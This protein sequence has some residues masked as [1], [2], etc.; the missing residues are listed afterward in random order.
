MGFLEIHLPLKRPGIGLA[1]PEG[2][3]I[4]E[5]AGYYYISRGTE[6]LARLRKRSAYPS[7]YCRRLDDK[8]VVFGYGPITVSDND[9]S[10]QVILHGDGSL[11]I[12]RDYYATLPIFYSVAAGIFVLSNSYESVVCA[13]P[14]ATLN[15]DSLL[16]TLLPNPD[17]H[18]DLW[19]EVKI[20]EERHILT[21]DR[22]QRPVVQLP[23]P[24]PWASSN[25][26]GES[27]PRLFKDTLE[28][29]LEAFIEKFDMDGTLAFEVSGGI[30]SALLPLHVAKTRKG[31]VPGILGSMGFPGGFGATQHEKLLTLAEQ[32]DFRALRAVIDPKDEYPLARIVKGV[33][34]PPFYCFSEIYSEPLGDLADRFAQ[35]GVQVVATGIGGDELFENTLSAEQ[36]LFF[37]NV[38]QQRRRSLHYPPFSTPKMREQYVRS[39]PMVAPYPLPLLGVSLHGA[40]LARNNIYI[41]RDIWPVSPFANAELYQFCQ[42]LPVRFRANKNILRAFYEAHSFPKTI[43]QPSQNEHFGEFFADSFST[44]RYG[45]L[46]QKLSQDSI[47]KRLGLIDTARLLEVYKEYRAGTVVEGR[48]WLLYIYT[49]L[50]AELNLQEEQMVELKNQGEILARIQATVKKQ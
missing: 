14:A 17:R 23:D 33:Q 18:A 31:R 47:T 9:E 25:Q 10:L 1:E 41:S 5:Q 21:I 45:D 6:Q 30:D 46:I 35:Q 48:K 39:A 29:S 40:Q 36:Q 7:T 11:A 19:E 50:C 42:G 4:F 15:H 43:Y 8:T 16:E 13:L 34:S 49:W 2:L 26:A 12:K 27:N 22:G 38:E 3:S 28:S 37:G 24:R 44:D 32:T 20:L